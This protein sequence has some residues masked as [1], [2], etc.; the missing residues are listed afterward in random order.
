MHGKDPFFLCLHG[1]FVGAGLLRVRGLLFLQA[2]AVVLRLFFVVPDKLRVNHDCL[3]GISDLILDL[4]LFELLGH[5]D[6][7]ANLW[8]L[9]V[10]CLACHRDI[11]V[12]F[13]ERLGLDNRRVVLLRLHSILSRILDHLVLLE[14]V[15][16]D[17]LLDDGLIL[18]LHV[19]DYLCGLGD[20][21]VLNM[22]PEVVLLFR[23][24]FDSHLVDFVFLSE[25]SLVRS[26]VILYWRV[27]LTPGQYDIHV[28]VEVPE[29]LFFA[30]EPVVECVVHIMGE[31]LV[32]Y[33]DLPGLRPAG[34]SWLD[35]LEASAR[36]HVLDFI[37]VLMSLG[38]L[39]SC[40]MSS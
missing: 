7:S 2:S 21:L 26:E 14:Q 37:S 28:W 25:C 9:K 23:Y 17:L 34:V 19:V 24:E 4:L 16:I 10:A 27:E 3:P 6:A 5:D 40:L 12:E 30:V 15:R 33:L 11:L 32:L 1:S 13:V 36:Q 29:V 22:V 38:Q 8:C 31:D 39:G 18:L 35:F 20:V